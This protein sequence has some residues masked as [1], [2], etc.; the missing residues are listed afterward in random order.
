MKKNHFTLILLAAL[1]FCCCEGAFDPGNTPEEPLIRAGGIIDRIYMT[2]EDTS[3][4]ESSCTVAIKNNKFVL[5]LSE[6]ATFTVSIWHK[7]D[8]SF[9][10]AQKYTDVSTAS[11]NFSL[12]PN[13]NYTLYINR[14]GICCFL[15]KDGVAYTSADTPTNIKFLDELSSK[16]I[17]SFFNTTLPNGYEVLMYFFPQ[18]IFLD[19]S[20]DPTQPTQPSNRPNQPDCCMVN[21]R[22][23][24]QA[25]YWGDL[26]LPEIDFDN[27]TL[28]L[29]SINISPICTLE[30]YSV[31]LTDDSI[32]ITLYVLNLDKSR[33]D[34]KEHPENKFAIFITLCVSNLF[35][36]ILVIEEQS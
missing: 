31:S 5:T 6:K 21:S 36:L 33:L 32:V 19:S 10:F 24:L 3:H 17:A 8:E 27:Y 34:N 22:E 12:F 2:S 16:E 13:G 23:E 15:I 28:I 29:G 25:L 18:N 7:E 20:I 1:M 11:I 35:K 14:Q 4:N 30:T 9:I 26:E